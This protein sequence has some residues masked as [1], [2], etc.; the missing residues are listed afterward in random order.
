MKYDSNLFFITAL[1]SRISV[2][3]NAALALTCVITGTLT[4]AEVPK[5]VLYGVAMASSFNGL[6]ALKSQEAHQ[7][8]QED[9]ADISDQVRT[10]DIYQRLQGHGEGT[11]LSGQVYNYLVDQSGQGKTKDEM[12]RSLHTDRAKALQLWLELE[13]RY[14]KIPTGDF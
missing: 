11:D 2:I 1:R 5:R 7:K 10:N 9:V 8:A 14:G 12:L 4:E 13:Q 3:T 6:L